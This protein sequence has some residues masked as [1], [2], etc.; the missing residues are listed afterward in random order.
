MWLTSTNGMENAGIIDGSDQV[1]IS[2]SSF[3]NQG[4]SLA[5]YASISSKLLKIDVTG[6]ITLGANSLLQGTDDAI[7]K[8]AKVSS[9]FFSNN[10]A[11]GRFIAGR[12]WTSPSHKAA[13][14]STRI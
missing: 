11:K 3:I 5:N 12:I 4:A 2:A 7:I 10:T 1:V 8:A 9:G 13:G 14:R 6:D